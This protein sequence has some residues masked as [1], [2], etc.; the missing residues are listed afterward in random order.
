ML[1]FK[2][3]PNSL[4]DPF[5][6]FTFLGPVAA[7]DEDDETIHTRTNHQ[8][9]KITERERERDENTHLSSTVV[10]F[11]SSVDVE[12]VFDPI[13]LLLYRNQRKFLC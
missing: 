4:V 12:G 1:A 9:Q 8:K 11:A 6:D 3:L 13:F 2:P 5:G 7:K 10:A